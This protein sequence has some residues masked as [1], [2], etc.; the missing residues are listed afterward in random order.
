M[1]T[2]SRE[3][4]RFCFLL[5]VLAAVGCGGQKDQGTAMAQSSGAAPARKQQHAGSPVRTEMRGVNL[6]IDPNV[7]LEIR[8]LRGKLEPTDKDSPPWFD[9]P[10]SFMIDIGEAEIAVT[11][12]S[13]AAMMNR[14]VF[15][16][17]DAPVKDVGIEIRDGHLIQTA[18]LKKKI[19]VHTT[20]EGDLSVTPE[21]DIRFHPTKIKAGDL[22]VKGLLDLFDVE[23]SEV[24]K[25]QESRGVRVV[26]NDLILDP[27]RLLPPPRIRGRVTGVRIEGDRIVQIFGGGEA[28]DLSPPLSKAEH[29]LFYRGGELSFGKVTMH[30]ADLQIIDA[31]P[32]DPFDFFLS[33]YQRQLVAGYSRTL[34]D[35]GLVVYMPDSD[36]AGKGQLAP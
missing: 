8:Q 1:T 9:E 36:E 35:R 16:G 21:G 11:P 6:R 13:M 34:E 18:T 23:L 3:S 17:P 15:S 33:Q 31:D 14:Y 20:L 4:R 24:I 28:K 10:S 29:Y 12:A 30:G 7:V 27:E 2:L 26:D 32:K 25:T 22:P 5:M 19:P